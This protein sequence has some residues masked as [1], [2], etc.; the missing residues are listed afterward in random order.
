MK[1]FRLFGISLL[2]LAALSILPQ[3]SASAEGGYQFVK[4]IPI[5]GEGGWDYLSVDVPSHRLFVSHS[6]RVVVVDLKT[7]KIIGEMLDTPGVHGA[8]FSSD[9]AFTSNGREKKAGSFDLVTLKPLGKVETGDDPDAILY[10]SGQQEVYTFNGDAHSAT[11][12][13]AKTGK[14]LATI[15][16]DGKPE[17]AVANPKTGRVYCNIEDKN[18]LAAIDTKTHQVVN[19]WP[20]APGESASGLAIDP[21]TGRLFL[22]CHNQLMVMMDGETG[23]VLSTVPIG[24]GV[25]AVAFDPDNQLAF[26]SC[27]EGNVTIAHVDG[28]K[29]TVVQTLQTEPRARTMTIDPST[30]R[31]Y[32]ASAKFEPVP[33]PSPGAS[34]ARMRAK[35]IPGSLKILVYEPKG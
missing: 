21:T 20:I 27:G 35:V 12:I 10:E 24:K 15:P 33:A 7:D 31:I 25:D 2:G 16:L 5:G 19:T 32:L 14:V 8:V 34:P 26:S 30:K 1:F 13:D 22:G 9:K 17:F 29:M 23:K 3:S 28:D 4:E 6:D 18:E 11:V